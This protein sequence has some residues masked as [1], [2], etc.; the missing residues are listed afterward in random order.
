MICKPDVENYF[1]RELDQRLAFL[2]GY[3]VSLRFQF[4]RN[5]DKCALN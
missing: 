3:F 4:I 2:S 1:I 5:I